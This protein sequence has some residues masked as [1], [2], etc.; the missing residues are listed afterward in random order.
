MLKPVTMSQTRT[1]PNAWFLGEI[2][3]KI[4]FSRTAY[5][6]LAPAAAGANPRGASEPLGSARGGS[7]HS[8]RTACGELVAACVS[9]RLAWSLPC[10]RGRAL[11]AAGELAAGAA[12]ALSTAGELAV[13]ASHRK[14][15]SAR[16]CSQHSARKACGELAPATADQRR[17]VSGVVGDGTIASR[18]NRRS[19]ATEQDRRERRN[20]AARPPS[21]RVSGASAAAGGGAACVG[22]CVRRE[23]SS[24]PTSGL[25]EHV[26]RVRPR[27]ASRAARSGVSEKSRRGRGPCQ[28][29]SVHGVCERGRPACVRVE[30]R[31]NATAAAGELIKAIETTRF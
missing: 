12:G 25:A 20:A 8:G 23:R 2:M 16:R 9:S 14:A 22:E 11:S 26:G 21:A 10:Q 18:H 6:A 29:V 15:E 5:T 28:A 1:S 7:Q 27:G 17:G 31:M 24:W 3:P 30:S 19:G 4:F 13:P